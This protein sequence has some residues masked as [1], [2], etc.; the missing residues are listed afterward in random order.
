L[1]PLI[2]IAIAI[3]VITS[4]RAGKHKHQEYLARE[5]AWRRERAELDEELAR[6]ER[7]D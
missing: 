3:G 6:R 2:G 1:F 7:A 5:A 4:V